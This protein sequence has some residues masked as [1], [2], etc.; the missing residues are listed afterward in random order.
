MSWPRVHMP[1]QGKE[2]T[3]RP[4]KNLVKMAAPRRSTPFRVSSGAH[5]KNRS[6]P[7]INPEHQEE[8]MFSLSQSSR[9]IRPFAYACGAPA[10]PSPRNRK[11]CAS[12][13]TAPTWHRRLVRLLLVCSTTWSCRSSFRSFR[14]LRY[15]APVR[16]LRCATIADRGILGFRVAPLAQCPGITFQYFVLLHHT[17]GFTLPSH[18]NFRVPCATT[19][20]VP[21]GHRR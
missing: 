13:T 17:A 12:T 10:K 16:C 3:V 21:A 6:V 8:L 11:R 4:T 19:R 14:G 7:K 1:A 9:L 20:E 2:K 18:F 5:C 15:S